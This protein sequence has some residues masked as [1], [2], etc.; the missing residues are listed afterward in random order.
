MKHKVTTMN[1]SLP[2]PLRDQLNKKVSRLA[3]SS[4]SEYVRD[5][6]RRDLQREAVSQVDALLLDGLNSG[7]AVPVTDRWWKQREA[8]LARHRRERNKKPQRS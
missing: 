7:A 3:Y 5:L 4:A 8:A 2:R 6:I 1:I